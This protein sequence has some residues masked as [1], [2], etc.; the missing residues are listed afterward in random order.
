MCWF[1]LVAFYPLVA[2]PPFL[3]LLDQFELCFFPSPLLAEGKK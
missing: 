2:D 3:Q 1:L